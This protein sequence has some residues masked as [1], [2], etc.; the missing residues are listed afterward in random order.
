[1]SLMIPVK[2]Y[3]LIE[4]VRTSLPL[5]VTKHILAYSRRAVLENSES[6]LWVVS[7]CASPPLSQFPKKP[8]T[9]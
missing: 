5:E 4:T 6:G 2:D 8:T 1:M 9:S 3:T 7:P